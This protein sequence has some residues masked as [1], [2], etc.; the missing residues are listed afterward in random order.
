MSF[1]VRSSAIF[2]LLVAL[3]MLAGCGD[4]APALV[5]VTGKVTLDGS[6]LT[7]GSIRFQPDKDKG[8][9]FGSECIGEVG[10]DGIY[11]L[12][13]VGK[14]GAPAGRDQQYPHDR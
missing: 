12:T 5:P 11:K 2:C 9:T 13:T 1:R 3:W 4:S 8:N 10:A 6:P 14:D 7:K